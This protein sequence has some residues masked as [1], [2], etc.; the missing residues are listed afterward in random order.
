M[1][2]TLAGRR[3][4]PEPGGDLAEVLFCVKLRAVEGGRRPVSKSPMGR[5]ARPSE[6]L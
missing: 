1:I 5:V 2:N 6:T 4:S 3:S